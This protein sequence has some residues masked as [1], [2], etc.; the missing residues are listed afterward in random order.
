MTAAL[1]LM[2]KEL[3]APERIVTQVCALDD[4]AEAFSKMAAPDRIKIM[5]EP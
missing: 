5:V 3:A 2:S 4:I 1:N